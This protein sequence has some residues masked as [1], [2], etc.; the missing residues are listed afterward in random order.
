MNMENKKTGSLKKGEPKR[1]QRD[2]GRQTRER[3]LECAGILAAQKGFSLVTSKEICQM[4]GTNLAAINYHFGSREGLY[5]A[6]LYQIH[7]FMVNEDSLREIASRDSSPREKISALVDMVAEQAWSREN[8]Q[9]Q[10]WSREVMHTD[11]SAHVSAVLMQV[12]KVKGSLALKL[13]SDYTGLAM[14][15][16]RLYICFFC[17]MAPILLV[18]YGKH[19][20]IEYQKMAHISCSDGELLSHIKKFCF[21]GLDSYRK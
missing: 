9:M 6:L 17:F 2:D 15:D 13:F 8:W 4:A 21:A 3:L 12:V 14:D 20:N 18:T 10:V 1:Q 19:S 5:E 7:Q 16:I 11:Q